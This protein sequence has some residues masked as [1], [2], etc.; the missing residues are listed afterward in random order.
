MRVAGA[1]ALQPVLKATYVD[2]YFFRK[3]NNGN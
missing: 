3:G 1:F 2:S